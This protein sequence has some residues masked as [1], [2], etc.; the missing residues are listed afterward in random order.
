[1]AYSCQLGYLHLSLHDG[2]EPDQPWLDNGIQRH[3]IIEFHSTYGNVY[4]LHRLHDK[5]SPA[6]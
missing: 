6:E 2:N 4:H 1:M 3:A 5:R